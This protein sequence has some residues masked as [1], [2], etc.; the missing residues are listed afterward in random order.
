[1]Q[2]KQLRSVLTVL[3][4]LARWNKVSAQKICAGNLTKTYEI[5]TYGLC[6]A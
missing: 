4:R 3:T 6:L 2:N 1:M 5:K